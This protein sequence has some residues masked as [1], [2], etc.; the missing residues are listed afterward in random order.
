MQTLNII[1]C[2]KLG[3]SLGQLWHHQGILQ[4]AGICNRSLG[5]AEAA[6]A[7]MGAG[8][9]VGHIKQL[10]A[11]DIWLISCPDNAL[12]ATARQLAQSGQLQQ[13][14]CVIHCSGAYGSD[15]LEPC[16]AQ[17]AEVAS[18]HPAMSFAEPLTDPRQLANCIC[19][20]EGS[21]LTS[22][23][24]L[25][26]ALGCRCLTIDPCQKAL[27]HAATVIACNY[28]STLTATS[29]Q[30]LQ[31]A[32]LPSD[33]AQSLIAPLMQKTLNNLSALGPAQALTGPI[34][35]GDSDCIDRHLEAIRS[36]APEHLELYREL[37]QHTVELSK[38]K[39][40][41]SDTAL[42]KILKQLHKTS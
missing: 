19:C 31:R 23:T 10:P 15:L 22:V 2:G 42:Q 9:A 24:P 29:L 1:G 26:E 33:E 35:R 18:A 38:L 5:S 11:A 30:L 40:H 7:Q 37:G 6:V 36:S 3:Q 32:G 14:N 25:F 41:A 13:G 16:H 20:C 34:A 17:G 27:Y 21:A 4:L 8:R 39:G 12:A 28:L